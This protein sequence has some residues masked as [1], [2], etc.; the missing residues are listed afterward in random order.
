LDWDVLLG[1]ARYVPVGLNWNGIIRVTIGIAMPVSAFFF[2]TDVWPTVYL[3]P[4]VVFWLMYGAKVVPFADSEVEL[5]RQMHRMLLA[6]PVLAIVIFTWGDAQGKGDLGKVDD[7][8]T[9]EMKNGQKMNRI[10]LRNFDRGILVRDVVQNR[11]EFVKW[12]EITRVSRFTPPA[13][14]VPES[15]LWFRINCSDLPPAP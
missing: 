15:C 4:V 8:Y 7:P 6:A 11:T 3:T 10:I 13:R 1:K 9:M 14:K 12:D 5:L 2:M